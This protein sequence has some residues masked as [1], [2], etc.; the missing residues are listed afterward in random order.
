VGVICD[1]T[2]ARLAG[3]KLQGMAEEWKL[4][5]QERTAELS[6]MIAVLHQGLAR[7]MPAGM[8]NF[9]DARTIFR[10][11]RVSKG[12]PMRCHP[13]PY[14]RGSAHCGVFDHVKKSSSLHSRGRA[15]PPGIPRNCER[16]RP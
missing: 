10:A 14:G 8:A 9:A 11:A 4:R 7:L 6:Q 5:L 3:E 13:L 2:D 1:I 15:D 12:V 16:L